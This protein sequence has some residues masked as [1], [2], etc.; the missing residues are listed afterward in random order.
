MLNFIYIPTI[1][2]NF[3]KSNLFLRVISVVVMILWAWP[4]RAAP[5]ST[6]EAAQWAQD[7]GQQLLTV[8]N[9]PDLASRYKELDQLLVEYIDLEYVARFVVGKYWKD[10]TPEQRQVY[11]NV[12][13]RYALALYK[14]FPLDFAD[15]LAYRV[16]GAEKGANDATVY[17]EVKASLGGNGE[18]QTFK[19]A[20]R[21]HQINGKLQLIDIKLGESSLILAYRSR[22]YEMIAADDGD[23]GWFIEDLELLAS[24]LEQ[25]N[26]SKLDF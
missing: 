2:Q 22:F 23:T 24:S 25:N 16:T 13:K 19:L 11:F 6:D 3:M 12:F 1:G 5:I 7:K 26:Q 20:F 14:T 15:K 4:L 8:F 9:N 17:A 10:M 21:L 18:V